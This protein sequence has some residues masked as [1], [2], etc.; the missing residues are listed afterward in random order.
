MLL[1]MPGKIISIPFLAQN[2]DMDRYLVKYNENRKTNENSNASNA[3]NNSRSR[4]NGYNNFHRFHYA[5][6]GPGNSMVD[7][8]SYFNNRNF[9]A[10]FSSSTN[11]EMGNKIRL[12]GNSM[13]YN[14]YKVNDPGQQSNLLMATTQLKQAYSQLYYNVANKG[15]NE[16]NV[17]SGRAFLPNNQDTFFQSGSFQGN[18]EF[19]DKAPI[20]SLFSSS[21]ARVTGGS[22]MFSNPTS[23]PTLDNGF[24]TL[25]RSNGSLNTNYSRN[26]ALMPNFLD[27]L[28]S[29]SNKSP[30]PFGKTDLDMDITKG[31]KNLNIEHGNTSLPPF[32]FTSNQP[33]LSSSLA[34]DLE[35]KSIPASNEGQQSSLFGI[36]SFKG[37]L[38][39]NGSLL[40]SGASS[41]NWDNNNIPSSSTSSNHLGIW[42]NDMSVWS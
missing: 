8:L 14:Q 7:S 22:A 3:A 41:L 34:F 17:A 11:N 27:D 16:A 38:T 5:K 32:P 1:I 4:H 36:E 40:M 9:N 24:E 30:Y 13:K 6:N 2:E 23:S 42:N 12:N 29:N 35:D 39:D 25:S 10:P 31:M 21:D 20:D 18:A 28:L 33:P 26:E 15:G 19:S 37:P